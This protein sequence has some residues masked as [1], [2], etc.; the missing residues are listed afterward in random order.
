MK[1]EPE[2]FTVKTSCQKCI[3]AIYE[4]KLQTGCFADRLEKY[5]KFD[6]ATEAY[7]EDGEFYVIDRSCNMASEE[8]PSETSTLEDA[9]E[10]Q[11]MKF[12]TSFDLFIDFEDFDVDDT[13]ANVESILNFIANYKGRI[14]IKLMHK[15]HSVCMKLHDICNKL[16]NDYDVDCRVVNSFN[17]QRTIFELVIKS[18]SIFHCVFNAKDLY[19]TGSLQII[20]DAIHCDMKNFLTANVGNL[21]FVY[22]L[23]YAAIVR[24]HVKA[25]KNKE[26]IEKNYTKY[27]EELMK[28]C[29]EKG[30]HVIL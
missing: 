12:S 28:E 4:G 15:D 8:F 1:S 20:D 25:N 26:M 23:L 13:N 16:V 6:L 14:S 29:S 27:Y 7:N 22:N 10:D 5:K 2:E 18:N 17:K 11:F 24:E 19:N 3:F 9:L 30:L 21:S